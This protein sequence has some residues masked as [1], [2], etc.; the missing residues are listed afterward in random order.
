MTNLSARDLTIFLKKNLVTCVGL[1][2]VNRITIQGVQNG[3]GGLERFV[4]P[5]GRTSNLLEPPIFF[6]NRTSNSSNL[7]KKVEP[8]AANLV[9][10]NTTAS[11]IQIVE[12]GI[13]LA[14]FGTYFVHYAIRRNVIENSI[15]N[16]NELVCAI[17]MCV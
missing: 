15:M 12:L 9:R 13:K 6:Q 1:I 14:T 3:G 11:T 4:E 8:Q 16:P 5:K 17:F 10:P 2:C 7:P